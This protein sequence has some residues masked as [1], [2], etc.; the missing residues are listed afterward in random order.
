MRTDELARRIDAACHGA[1]GAVTLER[2]VAATIREAVPFDR[3]CVLTVDPAAA[4]PTGGYHEEGVP[5]E[6]VPRLSELEARGEDVLALRDLARGPSRVGTLDGATSGRPESSPRYRDVFA[7]S[8]IAHEMRL[9]FTAAGGAWGAL[10]MLR[11]EGARAFSSAEADLVERATEAVAGAIRRELLLTEIAV[12]TDRPEGPGLVLLDDQFHRCT[13][14]NA[15]QRWLDEIEDGVDTVR[16]LPYALVSLAGRARDGDHS[17]RTRLRTRRG[18]W[19]TMHAERLDTG[20]VSVIVEPTRPTELAALIADAY[21]L[22]ARE[23]EVVHLLALG[24]S[25]AEIAKSLVLSPHTVDDHVKRALAKVQVRSRAELTARLFFDQNVP[26]MH[27]EV[28]VG[29]TGWFV[30]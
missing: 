11:D 29:G 27:A 3:W 21:G 2:E 7:P 22:T 4:L 13:T 16:E 12:D 30:R 28:P 5:F 15:A 18:R 17:V 6:R 20:G 14:T 10:I 26:R 19:L 25:R 9:V 24:Y 1:S 8:G 23:R